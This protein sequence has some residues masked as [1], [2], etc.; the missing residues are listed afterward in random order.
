MARFDRRGNQLA[1]NDDLLVSP[2]GLAAASGLIFVADVGRS[3]GLILDAE[4]LEPA[5]EQHNEPG[6]PNWDFHV[7]PTFGIVFGA[8]TD[9][10]V[11][12]YAGP[13][14]PTDRFQV[15]GANGDPATNN[16]GITYDL[17]SRTLIVSDVGDA[18]SDSDGALH[19]LDYD[20][21]DRGQI[22]N[23]F[24]TPIRARA[25]YAGANTMLGN[26][27]DIAGSND[28]VFVAE[29][30][31]GGGKVLRFAGVLSASGVQNVAPAAV[32]S[33]V[34][35]A[36]SVDVIGDRPGTPSLQPPTL[37]ACQATPSRVDT[38]EQVTLSATLSGG[39]PSAVTVDFGDGSTASAL[40]A[41]HVYSTVGTY[42]ATITASN[43]A[44]SDTCTLTVTV[45]DNFCDSV[46][47]LNSVFFA[48]TSSALAADAQG[49][50]DENTEV[51]RRC[52]NV[53]TTVNGYSDGSEPGGTTTAQDRADSVLDYYVS[54]G[55]SPDRLRAVGRGAES[56][57]EGAQ[58][59]RAD[60]I[61]QSCAG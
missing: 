34:Q 42:T 28:G 23:P 20:F 39:E 19:V 10:F 61:P 8:G 40:P 6:A 51:L 46:T 5:L 7:E 30:A 22:G 16:H 56:P 29:K 57:S 32:N 54:L 55:I 44:G 41:N 36:E 35:G 47:E 43:D 13:G 53:C 31:N 49:Q 15:L 27:V 4:T 14:D 9:G 24:G 1:V 17:A 11:N 50:L 33:T 37:S 25:T 59:R 52:P 26:P 38:G 45:G 3:G 60:S 12:V 18:G 2:K 48:F 58:S 21:E